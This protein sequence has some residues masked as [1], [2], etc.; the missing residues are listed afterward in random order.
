MRKSNYN[1][2]RVSKTLAR[3]LVKEVVNQT[4]VTVPFPKAE[5]DRV[6]R[7]L[8]NRLRRQATSDKVV[9]NLSN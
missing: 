1:V 4:P 5:V 2:V 3:E 9:A 7:Q 6:A 8:Y